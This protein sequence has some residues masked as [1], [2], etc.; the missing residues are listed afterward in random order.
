M[1]QKYQ[2]I[3]LQR[4]TILNPSV[5]SPAIPQPQNRECKLGELNLHPGYHIIKVLAVSDFSIVYLANDCF[6]KQKCV[7]KE[8][9]PKHLVIRDIDNKNV[10]IRKP[11]LKAKFHQAREVFF[12]EAV[13][14]NT[15]KH[16]NITKYLDHFTAHNTGYIVTKFYKGATLERYIKFEK[17]VS[18]RDFIIKIFIPIINAVATLHKNG[19]IHRDLKPNNIIITQHNEPILID[20]GSAI[21]FRES[22]PKKIF[23]TPGFSPLEFYSENSRQGCFS[24]IYSLAATFYYYVSGKAPLEVTQR[25]FDDNLENIGKYS[26]VIS[27]LLAMIIM[28]SLAVE[29]KKRF[30]SLPILKFLLYLEALS[31]G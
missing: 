21:R 8:F 10:I 16:R 5:L 29:A 4:N 20:F 18:I 17:Q 15:I 19:V 26:D 28:K 13:I 31:A 23:V 1:N 9:F 11:S 24:D 27:P 7:I 3:C 12:N 14:L 25:L 22:G 30:H 2:D 6:R